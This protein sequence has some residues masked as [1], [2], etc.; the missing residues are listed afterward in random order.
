MSG[1]YGDAAVVVL[2]DRDGRVWVDIH[3]ITSALRNYALVMT[4]ADMRRLVDSY[5]LFCVRCA[6][7]TKRAL[8]ELSQAPLD[9]L[10]RFHE[11]HN[12]LAW[13][14]KTHVH[15]LMQLSAERAYLLAA[16]EFVPTHLATWMLEILPE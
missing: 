2:F 12:G 6:M 5:S 11:K 13:P 15:P 10:R 8:R 14:P 9:A 3:V 1:V 16:L 7:L 4:S